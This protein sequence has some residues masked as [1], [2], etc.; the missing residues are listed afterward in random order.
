MNGSDRP[1]PGQLEQERI[2]LI[3]KRSRARS[4]RRAV[5]LT[6]VLLV[7]AAVVMVLLCPP[8]LVQGASMEPTLQDGQAVV[9]VRGRSF[10]PGDLVAFS[11]G[12][13]ALI[14]RVIAGEGDTVDIDEHGIVSVNGEPLREDYL[15]EK[16]AGEVSM[17]LPCVVPMDCWFLMGDNRSVSL[18]SRSSLVGFVHRE[19]IIGRVRLRV[20]PLRYFEVFDQ[21]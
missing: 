17:E 12:N 14:K 16:T 6:L 21:P 3:L 19:Q 10:Q 8:L 13:K 18:D 15:K 9:C 1:T 2:R 4:I 5:N 20:W 7:L 11:Y